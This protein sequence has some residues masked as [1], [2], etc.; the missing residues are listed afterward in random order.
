MGSMLDKL[1][2]VVTGGAQD[3]LKKAVGGKMEACPTCGNVTVRKDP[4]AAG[5]SIDAARKKMSRGNMGE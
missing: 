3:T 5:M 1:R 2:N 4:K